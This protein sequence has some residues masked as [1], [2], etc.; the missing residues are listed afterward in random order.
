MKKNENV[1][2]VQMKKNT[3][4]AV[5]TVARTRRNQLWASNFCGGNMIYSIPPLSIVSG[6]VSSG[7]ILSPSTVISCLYAP[8]MYCNYVSFVRSFVRTKVFD[9]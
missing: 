8:R 5:A 9:A 1:F 4:V 6:G 3:L 7:H 2:V